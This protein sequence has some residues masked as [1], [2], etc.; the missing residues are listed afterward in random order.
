[1]APTWAV[2]GLFHLCETF[3]E[4]FHCLQ[5]APYNFLIFRN[6]LDLQKA[7]RAPLQFLEL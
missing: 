3:F 6:K 1:M 2:P 4:V 5:S 7:Q